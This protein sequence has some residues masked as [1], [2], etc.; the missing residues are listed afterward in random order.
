MCERAAIR[1]AQGGT[2]FPVSL[3]RRACVLLLTAMLLSGCGGDDWSAPHAKPTA[4]GTLGPGFIDRA[5]P[6]APEATIT[7]R[8]GSW[9]GVR[10]S[11]GM[12]VVLLTAG[13][14]PETK[15]L[16]GAVTKWAEQEDVSLKTVTATN[17]HQF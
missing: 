3:P 2:L 9:D 11:K 6:P 4:I 14:A 5:N 10:P 15:T 8:P 13:E 16:A 7:P 17:A 1:P 12:R